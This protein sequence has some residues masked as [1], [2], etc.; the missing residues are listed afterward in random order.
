MKKI[1]TLFGLS[2]VL[3]ICLALSSCGDCTHKNVTVSTVTATCDREGYTLHTCADCSY[4]Y[5][6]DIVAPSGHTLTETVFA[7]LC[8]KEGYTYYQC[9]C[10]YSF[11]SATVPPTGHTLVDEVVA[12]VC[13]QAGYTRHTCSVCEYSYISDISS[14]LAHN[15][16]TTV[17]APTCEE[18]GYTDHTCRACSFAYRTDLLS[19][20]G[21][22]LTTTEL[23]MPTA[24][25]AGTITETCGTCSHSFTSRLAYADV[26]T[27][28]YVNSTAVLER[29]IDISHH[30][31]SRNGQDEYIPLNWTAIRE[32]GFDFVILKAG[33]SGY[34]KDP[35]FDI[36]YTAARAAGFKVGAYYFAHAATVD[37]AE[38]DAAELLTWLDGKQFDYPIYYDVEASALASLGKDLLTETCMA[39]VSVLRENG[40]Y[41]AIYTGNSFLKDSLHG[42]T[43]K[44]FCEVWYAR[45]P[46]IS[47]DPVPVEDSDFTWNEEKYGGQLGL[48]QYTDCGVIEGSSIAPSATVDFNYSYKD[49]SAMMKKFGLN[50][51][52]VGSPST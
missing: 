43:L 44:Q 24:T 52:T 28:A 31:Y 14:A 33:E 27:D 23:V 4:Q 40:Y 9:A 30:Q 18:G 16:V 42:E 26:Y 11:R 8:E 29:G 47:K 7:P 20:L 34:G 15:L 10:G 6:T 5:K 1:F 12:S 22:T 32:A 38:A 37:D 25:D 2:A 39:F 48:W 19:P 41:G 21:H 36:S 17:H 3:L 50:G 51:Y 35:T 45:Y 49:Y 13:D 46:R